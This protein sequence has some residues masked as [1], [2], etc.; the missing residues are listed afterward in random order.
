MIEYL[1]G[2]FDTWVRNSLPVCAPRTT[3][4]S[5]GKNIFRYSR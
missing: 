3:T 1:Q 5:P 4:V 2:D